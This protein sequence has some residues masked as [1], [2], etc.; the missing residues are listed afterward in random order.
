M[1]QTTP[2][3][4]VIFHQKQKNESTKINIFNIKALASFASPT[5][6]YNGFK[7][8][9]GRSTEIIKN[10]SEQN[11]LLGIFLAFYAC[12]QK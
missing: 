12:G 6:F 5:Y 8:R 1:R 4:H 7:R 3:I 2:S 11:Q 9:H 10:I